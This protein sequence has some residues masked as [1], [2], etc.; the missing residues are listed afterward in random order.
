MLR[1]PIK[2]W[3]SAKIPNAPILHLQ[4][5]YLCQQPPRCQL[6]VYLKWILLVFFVLVIVLLIITA[7]LLCL[8]IQSGKLKFSQENEC[9]LHPVCF[10]FYP[11]PCRKACMLALFVSI[12]FK[13]ILP[14]DFITLKFQGMCPLWCLLLNCPLFI[15]AMAELWG[16][17]NNRREFHHSCSRQ[18]ES[19]GPETNSRMCQYASYSGSEWW[20]LSEQ[21]IRQVPC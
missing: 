3:F 19:A 6:P 7:L 12:F 8:Y 15:A 1:V 11:G 13:L 4:A 20:A 14:I 17:E 9:M 2:T 16:D 10:S 18:K 5:L 21:A